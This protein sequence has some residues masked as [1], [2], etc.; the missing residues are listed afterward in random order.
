[1]YIFSFKKR[2]LDPFIRLNYFFGLT[3]YFSNYINA[4]DNLNELIYYSPITFFN[5]N[6]L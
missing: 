1:M 3:L 2:L 4:L 5:A 6:L